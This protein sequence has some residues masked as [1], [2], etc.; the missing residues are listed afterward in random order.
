MNVKILVVDD[1]SRNVRLLS[2][3]L[4]DENYTV[5]STGDGLSVL[6]MANRIKPDII[7]LDI[8]MP[9]L[10]GFGVCRLL[11]KDFDTK[12]IPVIMVTAKT[13]GADVKKALELGAFDYIKK[14]MDETEVIA[15]VQSALRFKQYQDKLKEMAMRDGLTGVYNHALLVEL[16]EKELAKHERLGEDICFAMVDIDYFKRV[17]D[18]FGHVVGDIILRD[19]SKILTQSVRKGDIIGRYG[20]E[21]FGIVFPEID[22][23]SV[24]QIC[25]RIRQNVEDN[26]FHAEG[27]VVH[28]TVSIGIC[29]K[30]AGEYLNCSEFVRRADEALYK[31]KRNGRNRV[32][33]FSHEEGE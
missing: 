13:D 28:V 20:G 14:P 30:N 29:Y 31:A 1:N 24:Y 4:E 5:Y 7:L 15:R 10:D 21:E 26:Y 2:D 32:E 9:G 3:I 22:E 33:V 12:D 16:L 6:E 11:K 18:S 27:R 25:D 17:N 8:M 23:T 19:L